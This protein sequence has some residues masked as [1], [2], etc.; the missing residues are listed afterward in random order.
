MAHGKAKLTVLGRLLLV[1]RVEGEGWPAATAAEA[2]GV[3]RAT[4]YKWLRRW[5]TEGPAGLED[6]SSR[7]HRSPRRTSDEITA[8][9]VEARLAGRW[10]PHRIGYDLGVAPSTVHVVFVGRA[11]RGSRRSMVRQRCL[12][13]TSVTARASWCMST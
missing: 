4:A 5:R 9:I 10:G 8:R 1:Q 3:S 2:Q 12:S 6:R 7:P 11:C 13:A